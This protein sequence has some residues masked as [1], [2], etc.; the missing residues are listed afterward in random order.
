M[1]STKKYTC[2][3]CQVSASNKIN[4]ISLRAVNGSPEAKIASGESS[5]QFEINTAT[6]QYFDITPYLNTNDEGVATVTVT[7]VG[8]GLLS[9]N[10][11]KVVEGGIMPLSDEDLPVIAMSLATEPIIIVPNEYDYDAPVVEEDVQE[12]ETEAPMNLISI[13]KMIPK[14]IKMFFEFIKT[15]ILKLF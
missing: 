8:D 14:S 10:N 13:I 2:L 11:L 6:E 1:I 9:V 7:N 15:I 12:P 5:Y 3:A 4:V